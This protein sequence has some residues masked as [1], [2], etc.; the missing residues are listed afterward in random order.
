MSIRP[1]SRDGGQ[2]LRQP[3]VYIGQ[4]KD[5]PWKPNPE[6]DDDEELKQT[7]QEVVQILGFDP[8]EGK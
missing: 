5:I 7:P 2:S 3:D 8:V 6:P 4:V 1:S